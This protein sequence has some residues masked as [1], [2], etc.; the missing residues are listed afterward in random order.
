MVLVCV[1][2][3]K[4]CKKSHITLCFAD[5]FHWV[6]MHE[7]RCKWETATIAF[8]PD[9]KIGLQ[10]AK[11]LFPGFYVAVYLI[12]A[13]AW[14]HRSDGTTTTVENAEVVLAAWFYSV[15]TLFSSAIGVRSNKKAKNIVRAHLVD[16]T[17]VIVFLQN[18]FASL[19]SLNSNS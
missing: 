19:R 14:L 8:N 2:G 1:C 12:S 9:Q 18:M 11:Y 3:R 5:W 15:F 6:H 17:I 4:Q 10:W 13:V 7:L 16:V